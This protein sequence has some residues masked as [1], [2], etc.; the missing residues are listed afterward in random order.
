MSEVERGMKEQPR[1]TKTR[2]VEQYGAHKPVD[3]VIAAAKRAGI[4]LTPS[5]VYQVRVRKPVAIPTPPA[6]VTAATRGPR[7]LGQSN[8]NVFD[9]HRPTP[10]RATEGE[11]VDLA[12]ELGL[13]RATELLAQTRSLVDNIIGR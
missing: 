6:T 13:V 12:L 3:E 10:G 11:F 4:V 7:V 2:F 5:N 8:T 1:G 9:E